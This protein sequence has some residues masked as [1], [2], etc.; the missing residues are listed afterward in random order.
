[1][2]LYPNVLNESDTLHA[3]LAGKRIAR[4]GDGEF[5]LAIGGQGIKSQ[6]GH[7][8]L[9]DRLKNILL[10]SGSCLVGIPNILSKTPKKEFWDK[11]RSYHGVLDLKRSYVSAFITRPDSAPWIDTDEYW[12]R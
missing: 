1:M 2:S 3:I 6:I 10:D 8:D 9:A 7:P 4:Y 11:F 5:K 12:T